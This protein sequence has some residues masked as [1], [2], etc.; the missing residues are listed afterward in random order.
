M[1]KGSGDNLSVGASAKVI[2]EKISDA[3][4]SAYAADLGLMYKPIS[5]LSIGAALAN[6]GTK[7]KFVDEADP[8]PLAG[9]LG[10]TYQLDPQWD[11]SAEGVY[12]KD[13]LGSGSMGLEW[14]CAEFITLRTGYNTAH[15]KE[16]GAG[17]G[18]TAGV[19]IFFLGPG[20]F[21]RL[22]SRRRSGT[23]PL[24]FARVPHQH[25]RAAG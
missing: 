25:V 9:R 6:V 1:A 23:N 13:G 5:R 8:L 20:I 19:G 22:C 10:A 2:T 17:S 3:S 12:R 21:L 18:I 4:A 16:L 15:I 11:F 14:R 24:F 7:I